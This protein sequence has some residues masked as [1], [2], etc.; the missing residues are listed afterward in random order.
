MYAHRHE[1]GH[2]FLAFLAGAAT[3]AAAGAYFL[4]GPDGKEHRRT[5]ERGASRLKRELLSRMNE[6]ADISQDKY[7]DLVDDVLK[8]YGLAKRFGKEKTTRLSTA[9]KKRWD[10]MKDAAER[11]KMDAERELWDEDLDDIR[12]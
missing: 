12:F 5:M 4:Y 3:A 6:V 9:L 7:E 1:S 11:A 8:R 2:S 10:E